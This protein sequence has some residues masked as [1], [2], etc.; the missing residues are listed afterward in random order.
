MNIDELDC[1]DV[2]KEDIR[3][4]KKLLAGLV[5]IKTPEENKIRSIE[6]VNESLT[7]KIKNL[8]QQ[9]GEYK[10]LIYNTSIYLNAFLKLYQEDDFKVNKLEVINI[11][12][13]II[14]QKNKLENALYV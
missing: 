1:Y 10:R 8:E 9:I 14:E 5:N 4:L 11:M 2:C 7:F 3:D 6:K 13:K 12:G